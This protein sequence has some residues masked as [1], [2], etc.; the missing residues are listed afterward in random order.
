MTTRN[1]CAEGVDPIQCDSSLSGVDQTPLDD[2]EKV[3]RCDPCDRLVLADKP[4]VMTN[5]S[6]IAVWDHPNGVLRYCSEHA[7]RDRGELE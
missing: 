4:G 7:G 6:N 3:W 5:C 1:D 2:P